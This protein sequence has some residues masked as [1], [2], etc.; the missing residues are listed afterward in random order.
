MVK[1][2]LEVRAEGADGHNQ[3]VVGDGEL[4]QGLYVYWQTEPYVPAPI[5]DVG[6][7]FH[8]LELTG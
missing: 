3:L 7:L 2:S 1:V 8:S 5:I 4:M 6:P